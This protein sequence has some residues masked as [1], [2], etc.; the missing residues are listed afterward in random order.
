[1][2]KVILAKDL[3]GPFLGKDSFLNRADIKVFT[4]ATNDDVLRI[5]RKEEINLIVTQ[6][7]MPGIKSEDLFSIIRKSVELQKVSIIIICQDTLAQRERCK[8]SKANAVFTI[9]VDMD[10]LSIKMQQFLNTAPRT[11]YRAALAVAIEGKF[12]NRPVPFWTENISANGMLIK[13]EE[14]LAKEAGIFFS[15]FLP[16]GTHVS[17]YGEIVRVVQSETEP[18]TFLYGVKFTNIDPRAKAAIEAVIKITP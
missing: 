16:D 3:E 7:D 11:L 6:L 18:G 5:S 17:G 9:P 13:T 2:K 1:M 10:L 8:R 15:F 14:P 4:A 12:K